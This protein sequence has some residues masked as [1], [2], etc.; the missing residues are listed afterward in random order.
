MESSKPTGSPKAQG[1]PVSISQFVQS[2]IESGL[3][4]AAEVQAL[5]AD[6]VPGQTDDAKAFALSLV[7]QK[8]L[9]SYQA[10][11]LYQ[12]K[13]RGLILGNYVILEKLGQGGMGMVYKARHRRLDRIVALKVLPPAVTKNPSAVQRFQRE[14]Q[15]AAQLN[16]PNIVRAY[17]ADKAGAVHF[18][19]MEFV[20]GS[21]LARTVKAQG[22]LAVG[23]AIQCIRQAATGLAAAHAAGVIHRDIKPGNLLLDSK[24]IVKVLDMGLARMDTGNTPTDDVT[25]DEITKSGSILGTIDYMAPEQAINTK[26]ADQ[27]AD[28]YSLGCTLFYLLT[29]QSMYRG[30]TAMEKLLAHREAPIPPLL[31]VRPEVPADLDAVFQRMVAKKPDDR[32]QSMVEVVAELEGV[33][34][35]DGKRLTALR[36]VAA[37]SSGPASDVHLDETQA[38]FVSATGT[39][40][41]R[42]SPKL[43][44]AWWLIGGGVAAAGLVLSVV[45]VS[46]MGG[47]I[48]PTDG[49]KPIAQPSN[50]N[51]SI[52]GID[53]DW[54]RSVAKMR[55][56]E[57][58]EAVVQR[59]RELNPGFDGKLARRLDADGEVTTVEL[60]SD[61]L[62]NISPLRAFPKLKEVRCN[63]S[64]AG[65]G[66]L[67]DLSPL[68]GMALERL[69]CGWT[70]V[71]DLSPLAGMPLKYLNCGGTK[72]SSL[73]PLE[74]MPLVH[75]HCLNSLVRD[76]K[77][78][79]GMKLTYCNVGATAINDLKPLTGMPLKSLYCHDTGIQDL[80]PLA[81]MK[82]LDVLHVHRTKVKDLTPIQDLQL[83][84]LDLGGTAV[85]ELAPVRKM[86]LT[87]FSCARTNVTDLTPLSGMPIEYLDIRDS[88][89]PD[90]TP[91]K[92][93]QLK[94][95]H[96]E[97]PSERNQEVVRSL[98]TILTLNGVPVNYQW[99]RSWRLL[100]PFAREAAT[101]FSLAP[102][103]AIATADL[104]RKFA[105]KNEQP[106]T[107]QVQTASPLGFVGIK[108]VD[109]ASAFGYAVIESASD[110]ETTLL[111]GS[112]DGIV[113]WLNGSKVHE[114]RLNRQWKADS[115]RV[116]VRLRKGSN[117]ILIRCDNTI[118]LWGF[119]I[120]MPSDSR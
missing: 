104:E 7:K 8:K 115:D 65:K 14:V 73:A 97:A 29:G 28:V 24:G 59:L 27:R 66:K 114:A 75:L 85:A 117:P 48:A 47:K 96:L 68:R 71:S 57:Q 4:P 40:F 1:S 17:D 91:L 100:G 60:L 80:Q 98:K 50:T 72:V 116:P 21:D 89:I 15:A 12:G 53:D 88:R 110:R 32:I 3:L 84:S 109:N 90:L 94:H 36:G 56:A 54:L 30:E 112:D 13:T 37:V 82:Q 55:T 20:E 33:G 77:P 108:S 23:Q 45:V 92:T 62:A 10:A 43:G 63:G 61:H 105:G 26:R 5:A 42:S 18:M 22:P 120:A 103:G 93:M 119:S 11:M 52:A 9:T 83:T 78:L 49:G 107:W 81:G 99:V 2:L 31:D 67:A 95:L 44:K 25:A 87:W 102:D 38:D 19:V 101:P 64:A 39:S 35:E 16:H 6:I 70:E 74:R 113:I 58:I 41:R 118:G 69:E 46:T 76:L 51:K 111:V 34:S 106:V 79:V 86:R